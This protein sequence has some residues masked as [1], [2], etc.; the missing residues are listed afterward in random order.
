MLPYNVAEVLIHALISSRLDYCNSLLFGL[1]KY[2]LRK[3]QLLQNSSARL[4]LRQGKHEHIQPTLKALHW[5]PISQRI[6][7]KIL[8]QT[9]KCLNGLAPDYLCELIS[10]S[11]PV[12]SLR[13]SSAVKLNLPH[14]TLKTVGA[15]SFSKSALHFGIHCQLHLD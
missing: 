14:T 3:L 13:S 11:Q 10:I 8:L 1:A 4:L 2:M 12:R 5:L 7:Y 6:S 15:K 9:Y